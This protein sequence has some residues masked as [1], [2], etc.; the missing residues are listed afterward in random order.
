MAAMAGMGAVP[1]AC[2]LGVA[3]LAAC[4]TQP[5]PPPNVF[6]AL[7]ADVAFSADGRA[8]GTYKLHDP[9]GQ[10]YAAG[11]FVDGRREGPWLFWDP[12]G[13]K[14][15]EIT[16]RAGVRD[17][18]C[19]MWFGSAA[20]AEVA[21]RLKLEVAFAKDREEGLE[22]TWWPNGE[23]KCEAE[24]RRGAVRRARCWDANGNALSPAEATQMARAD[25]VADRQHLRT[26]E[27]VV[28]VSLR[29]AAAAH[30]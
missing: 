28:R 11:E 19:R 30:P 18:P 22:R 14:V 27:E 13:I 17:G 12:A 24:L 26:M 10:L 5:S 25:L 20:F 3:C 1:L 9:T 6:L 7:R 4:A 21:G 29:Q 15:L 16:Y 8:Q 2:V 23:R